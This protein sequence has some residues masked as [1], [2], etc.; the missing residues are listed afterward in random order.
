MA[1]QFAVFVEGIS[2]LKEFNSLRDDIKLWAAQA[3]NKTAERGRAQAAREIRN[4]VN[5]P[6]Q[7]LSPAGKRLFVSKQAQRNDLE[8]R[9]RARTRATSLARFVTGAAQ[10]N[11]AGVRIEVA[12]GRARFLKRAFLIRLR[13]GNADLDTKSNLGLA[14]RLKAGETIKNK[15]E[16]VKMDKNLY[17]L[18]GPSVDQVFRARDGGGVA[19]DI[20]P[21]LGDYMEREFLRLVGLKNGR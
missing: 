19:D 5:L 21:E 11:K 3:I 17:L 18:Y 20:A 15:R 4:Q 10:I 14:I 12:P 8:A 7:Y 13:A 2:D 16:A 6:A 9:I 1:D